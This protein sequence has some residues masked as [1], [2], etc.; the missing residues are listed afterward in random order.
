MTVDYRNTV[1]R[2]RKDSRGTVALVFGLSILVLCGVTAL[3]VDVARAFSVSSR[4]SSILDAAALAGARLFE[5]DTATDEDIKAAAKAYFQVHAAEKILPGLQLTNFA[6][7]IDRANRKVGVD[8]DIGL[9]TTIAQVFG[10]DKFNF[11]R[12]TEVAVS[13]RK[14]ELAMVLDI[15]GSMNDNGKL[16]AMKSAANDVI[17]SLLTGA[18]M[19]NSVRVAV[20]P[21][22]A[23]VNAGALAN[24][25]SASP[26]VTSCGYNWYWGYTCT[27]AAG[28][29]VDTCVIERTNSRAFTD[30]APTGA[31]ILPAVPYTPY[32][33]YSCPAS[34]VVPLQGKSQ[35]ATIKSTI[36]AYTATGGTAGH[37]GAAWGWYL[38]SPKWS[39]VLPAA[40]APAPYTDKSVT[41]H[42][43]FVT[44]GIFNISY[45]NGE[46]TDQVQMGNDSYSQFQSLCT[47][48]KAQ[49]I[50]V[51][52]VALDLLDARALSE[53]SNCSGGNAF[54]AAD[55]VALRA[56][57]QQIVSQLNQ[58]RVSS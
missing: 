35:I 50:T 34:V 44:D 22:S 45:K 1:D 23:S 19:E 8:V 41:K 52:T 2:F 37:I 29:D 48:M 56:V 30:E 24:K 7:A 55:G 6:V 26:A 51:Y 14:I 33:Y 42:V 49:G 4:I 58:L 18:A 38:L 12:A 20:A 31:D 25:V 9:P 27:T 53:L 46:S 17:D 57:F 54:T 3:A 36:N 5:S 43:I 10:F 28:A 32:G 40:S 11:N 16:A 15:T 39:A 13:L 47:S 21:F